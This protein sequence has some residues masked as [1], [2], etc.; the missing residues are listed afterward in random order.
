MG[1]KNTLSIYFLKWILKIV[2]L[3]LLIVLANIYIF[4]WG[5]N[6][7]FLL[8]AN[9]PIKKSEK[10]KDSIEHSI[11]IDLNLIPPELDFVIFNN[12]TNEIVKSNLSFRM[13][14]K[15]V[16][17]FQNEENDE[18]VSFLKY[19]SKN[20]TILI[21]YNLK[22]QFADPVLR[23]IIPNVGVVILVT[24]IILYCF[25]IFFYIRKFRKIILQENQKL[26][27]IAE[28][29]KQRDLNIEFPKVK[30]IEYKDVMGAM[31]S[32][33]DALIKSIQNEIE[34]KNSKTEQISYLI[35]DIK[36]PLTIIKGNIELLE[37]A[38]DDELEESFMD[39]MNA[40]KQIELYI[41]KV[42]EI[43][44]NEKE[45]MLNK[46]IVS[47]NQLLSL[48][49]K[50]VGDFRNNNVIIENL[51]MKEIHLFIDIHLVIRA[52]SNVLLNGME[53]TPENKIVKLIVKQEQE[54]VQFVV[55]DGGPGFSEEALQKATQLFY[56]E[57]YGRTQNGHYGLGLAFT[58][59]VIKQHQGSVCV[60]NNENHFGEVHIELLLLKT[61]L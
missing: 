32:L 47:V 27:N 4:I 18:T 54:I 14:E 58:E 61:M 38:M 13:V 16:K 52:I 50:E 37:L 12:A 60:G 28:K 2:F 29:I 53:R 49:E 39:I 9:D 26:I 21:Y 42:I 48:L 31:E 45:I 25:I 35:H 56:T 15:A 57:N 8:P 23:K 30:F 55:I 51:T 24:S 59:K 40:I 19:E 22:V 11:D 33:S 7:D 10:I 6:N 44:L 34:S 1:L 5:F 46:E 41:Q 3:G 17:T 36:I 43:N 20:Q